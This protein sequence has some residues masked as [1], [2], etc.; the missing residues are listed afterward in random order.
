MISSIPLKLPGYNIL[1]KSKSSFECFFGGIIKQESVSIN[2]YVK[3]RNKGGLGI[4]DMYTCYL[5]FNG[6]YP[7]LWAYQEQYEVGSWI[8]LEQKIVD[9]SKK[10]ISLPS[11]WYCTKQNTH[12]KNP[13]ISFS[14][15]KIQK[16]CGINGLELQS[17]PLW[18]NPLFTAGVKTLINK[19]WKRHNVRNLGQFVQQERIIRFNELKTNFNLND[20]YFPQYLQ[21]KSISQKFI[22]Q[23]TT[24]ASDKDA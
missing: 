18:E 15:E 10:G 3:H 13:I 7:M 17:C 19:E 14:C 23:G 6:K 4:P 5:A 16:K 22:S 20:V 21:L 11:L 2:I 1:N 9:E 24:L 12:I 8:W